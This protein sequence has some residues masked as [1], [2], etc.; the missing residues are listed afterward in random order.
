MG[1]LGRLVGKHFNYLLIHKKL[2]PFNMLN[3]VIIL[4]YL[5]ILCIENWGRAQL[6]DSYASK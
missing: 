1:C 4:L 3:I 5:T 2:S 6:G